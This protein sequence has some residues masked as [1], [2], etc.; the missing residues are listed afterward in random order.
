M[1]RGDRLGTLSNYELKELVRE[2][3]HEARRELD[4][5]LRAADAAARAMTPQPV[6]VRSDD[7]PLAEL[8]D[9]ALKALYRERGDQDALAELNRRA[10][11]A[12][13]RQRSAEL[14]RQ[15][16][17]VYR[18]RGNVKPKRDGRAAAAGEE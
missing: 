17:E 9:D 13:K 5:R 14:A 11:E 10:V 4:R 2:G 12:E 16:I 18:P 8:S 7:V 3:D 1:R 15:Q 6:R